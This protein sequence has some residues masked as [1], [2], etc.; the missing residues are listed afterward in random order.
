MRR[1][2]RRIRA[3]SASRERLLLPRR[4]KA[5][6][7]RKEYVAHIARMLTL[8]GVA[9]DPAQT[10]RHRHA[11]RNRHGEDVRSTSLLAAIPL[12]SITR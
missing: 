9:A 4:R 3:A 12:P 11:D 7:T 5:V 6:E 2:A 1:S 10:G 8:L